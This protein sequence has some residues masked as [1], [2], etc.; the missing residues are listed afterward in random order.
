MANTRAAIMEAV[1]VAALLHRKYSSEDLTDHD[2]RIDVF[3][4]LLSEDIPFVLRPLEALLG[5]YLDD[6]LP[7]IIV[8]TQRPLAVQ[9]FTAAHELGHALL[10]HKPSLDDDAILARTPFIDRPTYDVQE[11]QADAFASELL[12][13]RWLLVKQARR[14]GWRAPSI[15]DPATIYQLSLRLG[16][17]YRAMCYAFFRHNIINLST[18]RS[19]VKIAPRKIKQTLAGSVEPGTWHGDVWVVT[20]SDQG[21]LVEGSRTDLVVV[22]LPEHSG[23][24]YVWRFDELATAGMRILDDRRLSLSTEEQIGGIVERQVT[25]QP[26]ETATG[27]ARLT[28]VRPWL[29]TSQPLNTMQLRFDLSGPL[30][31]G[32]IAAERHRLLKSA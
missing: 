16:V 24:G 15:A 32:L 10:G 22:H 20:P 27:G 25:A 12:I 3:H 29:P 23:S 18:C 21:L 19:L 26:A 5:A 6:P 9:R 4:I 7:G 31:A 8:T 13:P 2:G 28:E 11:I 30:Q 1:R 14:Q 17:S